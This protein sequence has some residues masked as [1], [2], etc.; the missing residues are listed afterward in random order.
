MN[1]NMSQVLEHALECP[2]D[3]LPE[4]FARFNSGKH[5]CVDVPE[6]FYTITARD[7]RGRKITFAFLPSSAK[8]DGGHHAVD[9]VTHDGPKS[10]DG[11]PLQSLVCF[12]Q[13]PVTGRHG[14]KD[15]VPTTLV[16]HNLIDEDG[17]TA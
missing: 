2:A 9:V 5:L 17:E 15:E 13:G 3:R 14:I 16:S 12:G 6:G 7:P 1:L 4:G 11:T 10:E 8:G